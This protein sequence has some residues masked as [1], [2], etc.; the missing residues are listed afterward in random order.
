M[1]ISALQKGDERIMQ[2]EI[3]E[4]VPLLDEK[5]NL[6]HAGF[7]RHNHFQ[8]DP[9]L[10]KANW[11]FKSW[12]YFQI[13]D[14]KHMVQLNFFNVGM[15]SVFSAEVCNLTTGKIR[16]D[17]ILEMLT[18]NKNVLDSNGEQVS[19][20]HY[21]RA[22]REGRISVRG[23]RHLLYYRGRYQGKPFVM[24]FVL[25]HLPEHES[26]VTVTPF[27]EKKHFFLT[28]KMNCLAA[29]G[30][31]KIGKK[32]LVFSKEQTYAVMDWG[33]GIWP[34]KNMWYWANGS[35]KINRKPFG[36][37][38]TW[39]FGDHSQATATAIFYDG[40]CHKIGHVHLEKDPE[41]KNGWMKL[42]H[43]IS[44]DGRLDL[45]MTPFYHHKTGMIFLGLI[46]MKSH[47]IHGVWNGTVTLDDGTV[48]T[49]KDMYAFCEKVHS[50]W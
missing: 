4:H 14:G 18:V 28:Q 44:E 38:L 15:A 23:N 43:F 11:R 30:F 27:K 32:K 1:K 26:L 42:W 21:A 16:S 6:I 47:Q 12:N 17:M 5:G 19:E 45:T 9:E 13:S 41:K 39:G 46:G 8:Y 50:R 40:I 10:L 31:V 34:Y 36:F 24:K 22:G 7:A 48:L 20:F 35:S 2:K 25:E 49:V 37:E 3:T 29:E 33:R